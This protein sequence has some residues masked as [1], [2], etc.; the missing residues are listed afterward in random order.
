[1]IELS[2]NVTQDD[3]GGTSIEDGNWERFLSPVERRELALDALAELLVQKVRGEEQSG[4]ESADLGH[5]RPL[6][7][8]FKAI[9][10]EVEDGN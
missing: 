9:N 1:M 6:A 4:R 7:L 8:P 5:E 2:P 10:G 3:S